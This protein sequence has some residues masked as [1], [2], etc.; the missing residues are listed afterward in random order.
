MVLQSLP[1]PSSELTPR[2]QNVQVEVSLQVIDEA[3]LPGSR[4]PA[5]LTLPLVVILL[6]Y[7]LM[8]LLADLLVHMA[9]NQI[10][11]Q[12]RVF[13]ISCL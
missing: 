3:G 4:P 10:I 5:S 11:R 6:L 2:T 9:R 12:C 1:G 8:D 7:Q 13:L